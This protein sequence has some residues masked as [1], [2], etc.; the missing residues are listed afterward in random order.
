[1]RIELFISAQQFHQLEKLREAGL[2]ASAIVR[3]ALR[4]CAEGEISPPDDLA[5]P[6]RL[7]P[8]LS[9]D[10]VAALESIAKRLQCS[11]S[12]ALRRVLETYL[13]R[14]TVAIDALF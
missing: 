10:D 8:Y 12:D 6:K 11:K 14:N 3:Q 13:L 7:S 9:E 4:K 5:R 1:M 2:P